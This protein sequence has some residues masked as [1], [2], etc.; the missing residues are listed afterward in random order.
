MDD[1]TDLFFRCFYQSSHLKFKLL[2]MLVE[3]ILKILIRMKYHCKAFHF[4]VLFSA[5][6][7]AAVSKA[8]SW[9]L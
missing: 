1:T 3:P 8:E 6:I 2:Q 4:E 5:L 7:L 9:R